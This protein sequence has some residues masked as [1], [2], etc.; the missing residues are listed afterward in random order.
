MIVQGFDLKLI[1][2]LKVI[3]LLV[4]LVAWYMLS[5]SL[6]DLDS[7]LTSEVKIARTLSF[8]PFYFICLPLLVTCY[9]NDICRTFAWFLMIFFSLLLLSS[10]FFSFALLVLRI[11][12]D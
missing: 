2:M 12:C 1:L 9:L 10:R 11:F 3:I 5:I 8:T 6:I 4:L 7:P